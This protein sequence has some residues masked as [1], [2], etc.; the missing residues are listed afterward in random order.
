MLYLSSRAIGMV[1]DT[2]KYIQGINQKGALMPEGPVLVS[3]DRT[4]KSLYREVIIKKPHLFKIA[5]LS[6]V[7]ELFP[8]DSCPFFAGFGN[9][10]TDALS[11]R[12]VKI[13]V[14]KIMII[15]PKGQIKQFNTEMK[16]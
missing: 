3:P 14:G 5:C 2:K 11:Y 10:E 6:A 7:L 13:N 1:G 9:R 15:N 16:A 8:A 12:A 4:A